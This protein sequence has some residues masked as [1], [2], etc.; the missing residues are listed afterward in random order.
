MS[1]LTRHRARRYLRSSLFLAPCA[2]IVVA[3]AVAPIV[4]W[5]DDETRWAL[6]GFPASAEMPGRSLVPG[7]TQARIDS[8]GSRT[9]VATTE[10]A[11]ESEY[12]DALRSLGYVR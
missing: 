9:A 1:W 7:S 4:R 3:L 12:H 2:S 5:I 6:F 8:F 10:P 11:D